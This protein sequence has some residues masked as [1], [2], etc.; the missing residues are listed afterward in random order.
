MGAALAGTDPAKTW[1]G[2]TAQ[3]T[4]WAAILGGAGMFLFP[5]FGAIIGGALGLVIGGILGYFGGENIAKGIE[6]M[7]T[8]LGKAWK[9]LTSLFSDR[10]SAMFDGA[11]KLLGIE[12]EETPESLARD[13]RNLRKAQKQQF[14]IKEKSLKQKIFFAEKEVEDTSTLFGFGKGESESKQKQ[15]RLKLENLRKEIATLRSEE[16]KQVASNAIIT[17]DNSSNTKRVDT[18]VVATPIANNNIVL[19]KMMHAY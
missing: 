12:V 10:I 14:S 9:S 7:T 3:A 2:A 17:T 11:K 19:Q 18:T 4:K 8:K 1:A 15:D 16:K 5:P 13:Q 6:D